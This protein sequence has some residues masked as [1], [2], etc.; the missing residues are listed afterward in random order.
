MNVDLLRTFLEVAKTR[1]FSHA[2]ENLCLTQSAVSARI[3]QLEGLVGAP[4]FTRQR[5]N[6]LLTNSGERLLPHAENILAAWQLTLQEVGVPEKKNAQLSLGGTSNLW[7]TFLQSLLPQLSIE[8]PN[9]YMR[10]EIDNSQHLVRSLLGRRVDIFATLDPPANN[11]FET[12]VIGDLELIMVCNHAD[13]QMSNVPVMGHVFVDW[14]TAFNIQQARLFA[15]PVAPILHTAQSRI[16]LEFIL[17]HRGAAYLPRALVQPYLDDGNLFQVAESL[18]VRQ[19]VFA[20]YLKGADTSLSVGPII[21]FLKKQDIR[22]EI[23]MTPIED[24]FQ[25]SIEES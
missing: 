7:D 23:A 5:N 1:H 19:E 10:T 12:E 17:S 14:G 6:I 2:A 24:D 11:D 16:A 21:N 25:L 8:F 15:E 4:I 20:V 22:P 3:K 13:K 9:L 18:E